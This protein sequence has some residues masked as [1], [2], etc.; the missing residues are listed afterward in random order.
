MDEH[1]RGE[2]DVEPKDFVEDEVR[3]EVGDR[4]S[5]EEEHSTHSAHHTLH[6][7]VTDGRHPEQRGDRESAKSAGPD[8]KPSSARSA[9]GANTCEVPNALAR[10]GAL[11][12][13]MEP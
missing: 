13:A 2:V 6:A 4:R 5:E 3:V 11:Y 12:A 7:H 1:V 8:A 9:L 10:I